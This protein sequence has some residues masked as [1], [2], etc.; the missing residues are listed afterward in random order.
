MI[1]NYNLF[2][3]DYVA[4]TERLFLKAGAFYGAKKRAYQEIGRWHSVEPFDS[5]HCYWSGT[6]YRMVPVT[7]GVFWDCGIVIRKV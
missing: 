6:E 4:G 7:G 5:I 2:D 3:V 1:E